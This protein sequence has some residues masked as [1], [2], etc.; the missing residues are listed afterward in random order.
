MVDKTRVFEISVDG[1]TVVVH[2][3]REV[4]DIVKVA[5]DAYV[6]FMGAYDS[7]D[8]VVIPAIRPDEDIDVYRVRASVEKYTIGKHYMA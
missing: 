1:G 8:V 2:S 5:A 7:G 4:Y 6:D 3:V